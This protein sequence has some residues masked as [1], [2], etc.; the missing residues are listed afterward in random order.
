MGSMREIHPTAI[1]DPKAELPDDARIGAY[2]IIKAGVVLGPGVVVHEH[3]Q[4]HGNTTIGKNCQIGPAAYVGLAPQHLKHD[5]AGTRLIVGDDVIIRETV[6]VHRSIYPDPN[7]ATRIGNRCMLMV[8]SH[9]GHDCNIG[10]DVILANAVLLGGHVSVGD[11][12][13]LGG[14]ATIHQFVRVG[15]LVMVA[16]NEA[17]SHDIPPF[18]AV[19]YRGLKGYNAIGCRRSGMSRESITS[20]R[21]A[22]HAMH[23][24]RTLPDILTAMKK[25]PPAPELDELVAFMT[26]P[27]RGILPSLRNLSIRTPTE[28]HDGGD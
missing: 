7:R 12:A 21:A 3:S 2:S 20:L 14:G 17:I 5:G 23:T 28:N 24:H 26:A 19:R 22:F 15:R 16:G 6:S 4:I 10:N 13:F 8:A 25:L 18:S 1:V 11:R 9:V 27:G